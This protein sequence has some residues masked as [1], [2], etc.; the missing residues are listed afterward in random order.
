VKITR[1]GDARRPA[2]VDSWHMTVS[3]RIEIHSFAYDAEF[4]P[5]V[6]AGLPLSA[7]CRHSTSQPPLK[8]VLRVWARA[9]SRKR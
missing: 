8:R 3:E 7:A 2:W 6:A 1:A 9:V 4:P 5:D